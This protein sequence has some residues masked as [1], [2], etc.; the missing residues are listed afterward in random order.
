VNYAKLHALDESGNPFPPDI[1]PLPPSRYLIISMQLVALIG[2]STGLVASLIVFP[3]VFSDGAHTVGPFSAPFASFP[4]LLGL[5]LLVY[6]RQLGFHLRY[7]EYF[8]IRSSVYI[9]HHIEEEEQSS[10]LRNQ[11]IWYRE[12][13]YAA[14][15]NAAAKQ[16][17]RLL[18]DER[19]IVRIRPPQRS[20]K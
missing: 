9:L 1:P 10:V 11:V 18:D 13:L 6:A 17:E 12:I 3:K 5:F 14:H 19:P 7:F 4:I 16:I 15:A 2:I 8:A 20:P